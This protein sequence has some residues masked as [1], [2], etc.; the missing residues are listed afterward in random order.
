MLELLW[1]ACAWAAY[2]ALHSLFSGNKFKAKVAQAW[3]SAWPAYRLV[4]NV[5]AISLLVP[6]LWITQR[7]DAAPLWLVP[8]WLAWP[9]FII[10]FLGFIW[11]LR[12]YDSATFLGLRQWRDN[13][14]PDGE[15]EVFTLSPLHRYVRHP[16]YALGLLVLW[17]RDLNAAW[18]VAA[19]VITVYLVI[20][21]RLEEN[22]LAARYGSAYRRYCRR[23]PGLFPMPGRF[24]TA[25]EA[26]M[27]ESQARQDFQSPR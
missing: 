20:G 6:A 15:S 1:I 2:G 22:K 17:T 11:S 10:A 3:P 18:L 19:L 23:V 8:G 16:W 21:S 26:R 13:V 14:G 25:E 5:L 24:L 4:Y 7:Y 9:I 27:L 12:W